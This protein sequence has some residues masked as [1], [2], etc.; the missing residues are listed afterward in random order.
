VYA[1]INDTAVCECSNGGGTE[2]VEKLRVFVFKELKEQRE[3]EMGDRKR[4]KERERKRQREKGQNKQYGTQTGEE[5]GFS[6]LDVSSF[7]FFFSLSV[8]SVFSSSKIFLV[9][10]CYQRIASRHVDAERLVRAE[11]KEWIAACVSLLAVRE[12]CSHSEIDR[13]FADN[14]QR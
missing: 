9:P 14:H 3:K 5:Q 8:A 1:P 2:S 11:G 6:F 13:G 4:K 7:L 10:E 12:S